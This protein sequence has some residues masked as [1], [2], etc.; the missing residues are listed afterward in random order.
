MDRVILDAYGWS[1][2]RPCCKF[3]L[4]YED[5]DEGESS[6]RKKPW[7]YRW[8]DDIRD[9]VLGR[10]LKLNR[11]RAEAERLAGAKEQSVKSKPFR[12]PKAKEKPAKGPGLFES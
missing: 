4:D 5:E 10:L 8:P 12:K 2:I 7:R 9:E 1:D 11:E 3:I 6:H